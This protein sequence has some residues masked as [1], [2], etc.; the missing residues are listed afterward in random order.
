MTSVNNQNETNGVSMDEKKIR[1]AAAG[2][3]F[4]AFVKEYLA[5]QD[6]RSKN[7]DEDFSHQI[8]DLCHEIARMMEK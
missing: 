7:G 8:Q 4:L 1:V 6:V 2:G 5:H 3:V